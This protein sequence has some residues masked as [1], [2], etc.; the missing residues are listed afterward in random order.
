VEHYIGKTGLCLALGKQMQADGH[1]VGY[2]KPVSTQPW[3]TPD[4]ALADED[5]AFVQKVLALETPLPELA[6]IIVTTSFLR[7]RLKGAGADDLLDKVRRAAAQAAQGK[8]VLL[9]EG[10]ASLREGYAIGLS[11]LRLAEQLD[12]ASVVLIRFRREMQVVDDALTAQIRLGPQLLGV[13]LN[14]VPEDASAF[15][16]EYARPFLA[17]Q[18]TPILGALPSIPVLSALSIAELASILKAEVLTRRYNPDA[19]CERFTIGAMTVDAAISRFRRQKNKAVIT[20][21]DR[22][23]IMLAALETSTRVLILTGNIHPSPLIIQQ[24]EA[25]D[26]PVLLVKDNTMET[27]NAIERVYGKTPLGAPEKL[28]AFIQLTRD[29]VDMAAIYRGLGLA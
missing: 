15:I 29:H 28:E 19:L 27:L 24:A 12:A 17:A 4:G 1:R 7:E 13:I 8:D 11:N 14:Q 26:V 9:L 20:G 22:E 10:G 3:R 16:E 23:D 6:P 25:L 5:A 21:G 2:L 18:G